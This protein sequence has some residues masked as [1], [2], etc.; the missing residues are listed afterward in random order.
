MKHEQ[1][2]QCRMNF[3]RACLRDTIMNPHT[4]SGN[5]ITSNRQSSDTSN[6]SNCLRDDGD[7]PS[8]ISSSSPS[9]YI[10]RAHH[11]GSWYSSDG[12]ELDNLLTKFLEDA[13]LDMDGKHSSSGQRCGVPN[14]CIS[15]H[16]G[17]RY[18]GQTA[19]YSYLALG[20]ALRKNPLLRTVVIVSFA[21]FLMPCRMCCLSLHVNYL[22][23][24]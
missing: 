8:I 6:G 11:A 7:T 21:M 10:R 20:E 5:G 9:S 23:I 12:N 19:A 16:A 18:S 4:N 13:T 17:F 22:N 3:L 2:C 14:A 15:P 1:C 24:S